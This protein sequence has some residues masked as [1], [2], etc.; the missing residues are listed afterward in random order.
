[1]LDLSFYTIKVE[2]V[3]C[4]ATITQE[5]NVTTKHASSDSQ[6]FNFESTGK[7]PKIVD[8]G[9]K[10]ELGW[11][12]SDEETR[13]EKQVISYKEENEILLATPVSYSDR[14]ISYQSGSDYMVNYVGSGDFIMTILPYRY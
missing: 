4:G 3:D 12:E 14:F 11:S 2:E 1:M 8:L 7:I 5:I 6:K 9:A 10:L 13:V